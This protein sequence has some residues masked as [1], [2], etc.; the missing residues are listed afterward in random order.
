MEALKTIFLF[1]ENHDR[2]EGVNMIYFS[3]HSDGYFWYL[4]LRGKQKIFK[5]LKQNTPE[6]NVP[7]HFH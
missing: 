4:I 1:N 7:P 6:N 3:T 5:K 2:R